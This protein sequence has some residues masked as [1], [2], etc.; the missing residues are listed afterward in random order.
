VLSQLDVT[1][2]GTPG[3]FAFRIASFQ[4]GDHVLQDIP[5]G[6]SAPDNLPDRPWAG[7]LGGDI[8]SRFRVVLDYPH[9]RMGLTPYP[10]TIEDRFAYDSLGV[11]ATLIPGA[12]NFQIRAVF[13][14][15]P[16]VAAGLRAGDLI[17]AIDDRPV[18]GIGPA[19]LFRMTHAGT[20]ANHSLRIERDGHIETVEITLRERI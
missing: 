15:S 18:T 17:H 8:L 12:E 7:T 16:A 10:D 19:G 9:D 11:L 3:M 4:L 2:G 13:D 5:I 6:Y 14:G 20:P 1:V